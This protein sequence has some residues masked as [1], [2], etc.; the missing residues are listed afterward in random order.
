MK[1]IFERSSGFVGALLIAISCVSGISSAY[2]EDVDMGVLIVR[3]DAYGASANDEDNYQAEDTDINGR[4]EQVSALC[5]KA[6]N[7]TAVALVAT[8]HTRNWGGYMS[9]NTTTVIKAGGRVVKNPQKGNPNHCLI[10]GVKL[11]QITGMW[12]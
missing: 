1:S 5:A 12:H 2:A 6:A 11:S 8:D 10:N 3:G 4:L 9:G 7:Q